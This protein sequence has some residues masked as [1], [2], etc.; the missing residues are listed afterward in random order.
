MKFTWNLIMSGN[1]SGP[2]LI[3]K[4]PPATGGYYYTEIAHKLQMILR[5]TYVSTYILAGRYNYSNV[6]FLSIFH[7][8]P[9]FLIVF[10]AILLPDLSALDCDF[11][12]LSFDSWDRKPE[13][14]HW[15]RGALSVTEVPALFVTFPDS[16][17][18]FHVTVP[19]GNIN[20]QG[21]L[22]SIP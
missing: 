9:C 2:V 1:V 10:E 22:K 3:S 16:I 18:T 19:N 20:A 21:K 5:L 4:F 7:V 6:F 14:F 13:L 15:S 12:H 8:I 11:C 17:G